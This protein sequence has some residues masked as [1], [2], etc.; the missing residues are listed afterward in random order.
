MLPVAIVC[1]IVAM[2]ITVVALRAS[3]RIWCWDS[4]TSAMVSGSGP[5][6]R[7]DPA[8]RKG[9]FFFTHAYMMPSRRS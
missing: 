3:T 1:S 8:S 4:Y 7:I 5:S 2:Q 6:S 9:T